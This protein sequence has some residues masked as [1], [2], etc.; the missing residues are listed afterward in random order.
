LHTKE[1]VKGATRKKDS[2]EGGDQEVSVVMVT[3]TSRGNCQERGKEGINEGR[4]AKKLKKTKGEEG[5]GSEGVRGRGG[6]REKA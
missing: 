1:E 6:A 5:R 4:C 2:K 3:G